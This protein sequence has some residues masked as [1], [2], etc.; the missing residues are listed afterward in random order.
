MLLILSSDEIQLVH[1]L[2]S[3]IIENIWVLSLQWPNYFALS[4]LDKK[5]LFLINCSKTKVFVDERLFHRNTNILDRSCGPLFNI[6]NFGSTMA[7][8]VLYVR[9]P[10]PVI[11]TGD[12][13]CIPLFRNSINFTLKYFKTTLKLF[14]CYSPMN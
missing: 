5:M 6:P 8:L 10:L 14:A 1:Y 9:F 3:S 13:Q 4:F 11:L 12:F 2:L 7:S